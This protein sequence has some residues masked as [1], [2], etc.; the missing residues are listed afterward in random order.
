MRLRSR[1]RRR[2]RVN[3]RAT[4]RCATHGGGRRRCGGGTAGPLAA[5]LGPALCKPGLF[6]AMLRCCP[7]RQDRQE[8]EPAA[9]VACMAREWACGRRRA[10]VKPWSCDTRRRANRNMCEHA[11][12]GV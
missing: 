7:E 6:C 1:S 3:S 12:A 9:L 8:R 11:Q 10:R 2:H 5:S 4:Q